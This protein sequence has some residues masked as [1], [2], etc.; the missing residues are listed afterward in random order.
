[1]NG[2][3][4]LGYLTAA[5]WG[6]SRLDYFTVGDDFNVYHKF[7]D[8]GAWLPEGKLESLGNG[9]VSGAVAAASWGPGRLDLVAST[10]FGA[11][12]HKAWTGDGWFPDGG[13]WED[14]G[15]EF[16]S[17]PTVVSWGPERLDIFGIDHKSGSIKHKFWYGGDNWAPVEGW[18]DLGGGPFIGT[19]LATSWGPDRL[20]IWAVGKD[21]QLNHKFWD[22]GRYSEWE[23]LGGNF[24]TAPAVTHWDVGRIDIVGKSTDGHY[25]SKVWDGFGWLPT[26]DGYFD[27]GGS[28]ASEP[29]LI[30]TK[31]RS[32][33]YRPPEF[34][35]LVKWSSRFTDMLTCLDFLYV[36]GTDKSG[37]V[38]LQIWEG[39][40]WLP[41]PANY[42]D[43]GDTQKPY[44]A[45]KDHLEHSFEVQEL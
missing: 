43:L 40:Q 32:K 12:L 45:A 39:S 21:G 44:V 42:W 11:Y 30:S 34:I 25:R 5:S 17:D 19:P 3:S 38:K 37:I 31:G 2:T 20:D 26:F 24:T 23:K 28:F 35:R 6:P 36:I 7:W 10:L 33:Y 41:G 29:Q 4:P 8:G 18:E 9:D 1:M 16:A 14:F 22:G 27:K 15:G 13:E